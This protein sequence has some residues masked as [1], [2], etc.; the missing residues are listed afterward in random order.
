MLLFRNTGIR[1]NAHQGWIGVKFVASSAA[2]ETSASRAPSSQLIFDEYQKAYFGA[3]ALFFLWLIVAAISATEKPLFGQD[4]LSGTGF[5]VFTIGAYALIAYFLLLA[6]PNGVNALPRALAKATRRGVSFEEATTAPDT[7]EAHPGRLELILTNPW[8]PVTLEFMLVGWLIYASGGI[9]NS[10]Y[11]PVP[12][13][14]IIIGQNVYDVRPIVFDGAAGMRGIFIFAARVAH[15][16]WYPLL[17]SVTLLLGLE[18]LQEWR[19]LV[20]R[21]APPGELAFTTLFSLFVCMCA[22]FVTRCSD[23]SAP[24][25]VG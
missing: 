13:G 8:V 17:L 11:G 22:T 3:A 24:Q 14:M 2:S 12:I 16:Y 1:S 20:Q 5:V 23:R 25:S 10:P 18:L 9:V 19:P 21:T 7:F 15:Q 4:Q 6:N